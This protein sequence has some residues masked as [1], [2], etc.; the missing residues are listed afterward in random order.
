MEETGKILESLGHAV[1][2]AHPAVLD[3]PKTG[4]IF[5]R[6]W[7]VRLLYALESFERKLGKKAGD[8]EL[9]PDTQFWI[10][11]GRTV[12]AAEYLVALEDMDGFSRTMAAWWKSGF[13]LLLTPVTGTLT[14]KLGALGMSVRASILWTPFTSHCNLTGQPALSV[15][16]HWTREGLPVGVQ[17]VA[18][19]ARED[20]LIRTAA[21]LEKA[22]PWAKRMPSVHA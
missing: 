12:S 17:L 2:L 20:V 10:K 4:T 16:M 22:K 3:E 13:D 9:D 15:P 7:P 8:G 14:P 21:Q 1:E 18:G 6:I 19:Y 11:R 5:A